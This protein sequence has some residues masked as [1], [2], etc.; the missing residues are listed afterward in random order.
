[1]NSSFTRWRTNKWEISQLPKTKTTNNEQSDT[2]IV[3]INIGHSSTMPGPAGRPCFASG[4]VGNLTLCK[5]FH[6]G[7]EN[8]NLGHAPCIQNVLQQSSAKVYY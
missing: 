6:M 8:G 1:M 4:Q 3:D 7:A 5:R 2:V